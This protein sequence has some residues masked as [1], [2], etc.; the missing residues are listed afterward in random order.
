MELV[1]QHFKKTPFLLFFQLFINIFICD[2]VFCDRGDFGKKQSLIY[3]KAVQYSRFENSKRWDSS[4]F[5]GREFEVKILF[6]AC[7]NQYV[8]EF[9][10]KIFLFIYCIFTL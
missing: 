10:E 5:E 8:V 3:F 9:Q 1:T 2:R 4:S 6:N 7:K